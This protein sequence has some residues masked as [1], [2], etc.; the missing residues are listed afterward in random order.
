[1]NYDDYIACF[2][3]GDDAALVDRFFHDDLIFTGGARDYR[4]KAELMGFLGWAHDGLREVM[5]PQVVMREGDAIFAE[6]DMDFHAM[7]ERPEFPFAHLHAG[8]MVSVKFFVTYRLSEGR[9][10]EL[11]AMTWP[12]EKGVSRIPRLGPHP[13]QI[14]AFHSYVAAFSAADC[15]RFPA[16][17][18]DDVVLTLGSVPPLHGPDGIAG[19][20]RPMFER[21]REQLT[22]HTVEASE[23]AI[24]IDATTRFTAIRDAPDFVVGAL[25]EGDHIEGRVFVDYALR[26]GLISRISVRRNGDMVTHRAKG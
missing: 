25:A 22:L 21:I 13:S 4:G 7:R 20:Y 10:A 26:D 16:F 11:K 14:A 17:Y 18:T 6:I 23:D 2:N 12:P 3:T 1:M 8:E 19:F 9:I 24:H 15:D 5:R